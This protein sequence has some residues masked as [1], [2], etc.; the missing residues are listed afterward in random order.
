MGLFD[1]DAERDLRYAVG[2]EEGKRQSLSIDPH[3]GEHDP[4]WQQNVLRGAAIGTSEHRIEEPGT[5]TLRLWALDP[6][7]VVDRIV[8]YAD[9]ERTTYLGPR[10]TSVDD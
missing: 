9:G 8:V 3:G 1:R 10:E 7:L 5:H 4:E 6:G 2:F